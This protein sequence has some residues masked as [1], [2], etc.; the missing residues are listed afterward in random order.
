MF[1]D[2]SSL[3]KTEN[4]EHVSALRTRI[5]DEQRLVWQVHKL[6]RALAGVDINLGT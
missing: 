2:E 1:R 6:L 4:V 5:P 3:I